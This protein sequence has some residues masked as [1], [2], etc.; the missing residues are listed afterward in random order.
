MTLIEACL[1]VLHAW[2]IGTPTPESA[3]MMGNN[4]FAT[5]LLVVLVLGALMSR[6]R[7]CG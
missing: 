5:G 2:F 4:V 3:A 6:R 7:A 1:F